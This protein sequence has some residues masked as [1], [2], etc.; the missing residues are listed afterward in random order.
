MYSVL[1]LGSED[2]YQQHSIAGHEKKVD[3]F[4]ISL[5]SIGIA[6][7]ENRD[8]QRS[9]P[10]NKSLI[11]AL[12][13]LVSLL[14]YYKRITLTNKDRNKIGTSSGN[15]DRNKTLKYYSD[16]YNNNIRKNLYRPIAFFSGHFLF[17]A[18]KCI[19]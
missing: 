13:H 6:L 4:P 14:K 1:S 10:L 12:I 5:I 16:S 9:L 19:K 8:T 3:F 17:S 18:G 2:V 11:F 15:I 7:L